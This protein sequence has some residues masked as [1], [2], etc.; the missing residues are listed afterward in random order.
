MGGRDFDDRLMNDAL[1]AVAVEFIQ[2]AKLVTGN[3]VIGS[4]LTV[5]CYE[6]RASGML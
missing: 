3:D 5:E 2:N 1:C 6:C 4:R